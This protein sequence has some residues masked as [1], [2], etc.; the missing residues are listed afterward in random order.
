MVKLHD[1]M[2]MCVCVRASLQLSYCSLDQGIKCNL[3]ALIQLMS[4]RS[5]PGDT[6]RKASKRWRCGNQEESNLLQ[7]LTKC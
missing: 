5:H 4:R 6:K 2:R 7:D 3:S 1:C